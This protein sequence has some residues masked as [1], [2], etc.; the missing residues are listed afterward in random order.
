MANLI[1]RLIMDASQYDGGLQKAQ[2]GLDK[3]ID[4]N[5]SL[6]TVM[7]NAK[8][9][10][11]KMAGAIGLAAGAGE[12]FNRVLN[13][14]QVL[15]DA[16]AATMESAKNSIDEFFYSL[17]SGDFT[18]FLNGL[19]SIIA[20]SKDAYSALDQL[21]NTRISFDFYQGKF[22]EAIAKARLNAKNKQLD[23][24]ERKKSFED[25]DKELKKK[26]E[27]G[28][29]VANDALNALTES[30]AVGTELRASDIKLEDFEK[31]MRIDLM[32]SASREREKN[33][34]AQQY[35]EYEKLSDRIESDRRVDVV[36]TNDYGRTK[37]I[38]DAAKIAQEGAA[39]RYKDAIIYN[40][41]LNKL[42]DDD[43]IKLTELGKQYYSVSQLISQQR[44]EY[45][46]SIVEFDN[47]ITASAKA[48]E[49]AANASA[50]AIREAR[51]K[52]INPFYN[53]EQLNE[54]IKTVISGS[55]ALSDEVL[56]A[57]STGKTL[58][59]LTQPIQA[60]M[61][62][63]EDEKV[64]GEDPTETLRGKVQM[65]ELAQSKIQEYTKMLSVA[66]EDEKAYLN[67]QIAIWQ[68]YAKT[69][70]NAS[71]SK[72]TD[73]ISEDLGKVGNSLN[74]I[75]SLSDSALGQ[76][77]SYFGGITTAVAAAIPAITALTETKKEEANAN[78]E[79]A[80]SG[81]AS[82]V[83]SIPIVGAIMAVAA[84][85]SVIAAMQNIPSFAEG[86]IVGGHNYM[87]GITARVSS[88]EMFINEADQKKLYDSIHSGNIGNGGGGRTVVT[89]E[90][91]VT[92]I[93]NYGKR[94]GKGVILKG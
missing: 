44:Q 13:S 39:E 76:M 77:L 49:S 63:I 80:V 28:K 43:L 29:T 51:E 19:D 11:A 41:L 54:E 81:A 1:T 25:W 22:D 14:S 71:D 17:G 16:T 75:G 31:V 3:F 90:Q 68:K 4:K 18:S 40:K 74:Q 92:V 57:I 7:T 70:S 58:P 5:T 33:Y 59:V 12:A 48:Q 65:Y 73:K 35:E 45:N 60:A 42:S 24:S 27:A 52:N 34:W 21:G 26:E 86:G 66:N 91:I 23:E 15:G 47:S 50:K 84:V 67:E 79:A 88:G 38:N 82:S 78:L 93:N 30:I 36:R 53:N 72:K 87:D 64:E 94:T 20:K 55:D 85:A 89:G 46:E 83:A 69:I 37:S 10:I 6:S 56:K 62:D 8:G 2:K 32:P 9:V 61:V